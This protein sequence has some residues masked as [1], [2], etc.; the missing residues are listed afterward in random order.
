[1]TVSKNFWAVLNPNAESHL[2]GIKEALGI[3]FSRSIES[4]TGWEKS[5]FWADL[6]VPRQIPNPRMEWLV[7]VELDS[8]FVLSHHRQFLKI[9]PFVSDGMIGC[10]TQRKITVKLRLDAE[11]IDK[12]FAEWKGVRAIRRGQAMLYSNQ[13]SYAARNWMN[14]KLFKMPFEVLVSV[15]VDFRKGM[16][17]PGHH[18]GA[19][20]DPGCVVGWHGIQVRRSLAFHNLL[21]YYSADHASQHTTTILKPEKATLGEFIAFLDLVEH[22]ARKVAASIARRTAPYGPGARGKNYYIGMYTFPTQSGSCLIC[23]S[24]SRMVTESSVPP[25][26]LQEE[27][28]GEYIIDYSPYQWSDTSLALMAPRRLGDL[29]LQAKAVLEKL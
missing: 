19:C 27:Y 12:T 16:G 2:Y 24:S 8:D 29:S 26:R 18:Q 14:V 22:D 21:L 15:A 25:P 6:H 1:M 4:L 23:H 7:N 11:D 9:K 17:A 13:G 28:T 5:D 10:L 3:R 20:G